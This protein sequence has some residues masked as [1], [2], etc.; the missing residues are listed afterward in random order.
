M[1]KDKVVLAYSG[2]LDT[3]C[4]IRWLIDNYDVDVVCFSAFIGE[5]SDKEILRKRAKA[6]G[7]KKVY[8]ED[9]KAE[10]AKDF[11]VPSLRAHATYEDNY[12]LATAIGRP[13]ISK[14]LVEIA[15]KEGARFVA[16]GCTGKG[17]DQVRLELGVRSLD[18]SLKIL[19]P[20]REWEFKSREEEI[21]YAKEKN[22]LIDVTKKSIY[23]ID[24]N[25]WGAAIEAGILEDPW[26]EPLE[27]AYYMTKGKIPKKEKYIEIDFKNGVPVALDGKKMGLVALIEKL[28]DVAGEYKVGRTDVIENRLVGIKSREIY[29]AP[30]AVVLMSAHRELENLVLDRDLIHYKKSL[31]IKYGELAYNGLWFS[32]TREALDAFFKSFEHLI[33]GSV[34]IKLAPY[35]HAIVGRKSKMSIY[36]EKLATYS[37][38]D[39]FDHTSSE[40]FIELWGLS[41][42]VRS[43]R[44]KK[45]KK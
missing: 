18:P 28:N 22:L 10:F 35:S 3:C 26:T 40:G 16:H 25:I 6:A 20:L 23:S 31:S 14:H 38:D 8:I 37:T 36:E 9:L 1:A 32:S 11:I 27:S 24:R 19:A 43:A 29:E 4:C 5:A 15:H 13:L 33:T 44:D 17:N 42:V 30:A 7:A 21:D 45:I 12:L 2:G 41:N 34:R 39:E